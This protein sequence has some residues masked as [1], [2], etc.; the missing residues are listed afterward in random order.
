[1]LTWG[2]SDFVDEK[3]G[4]SDGKFSM[5]LQFPSEEYSTEDT[6]A[7]L[8]N[9]KA[10]E[11]KIKELYRYYYTNKNA[12]IEEVDCIGLPTAYLK[13]KVAISLSTNECWGSSI[14]IF[15]ELINADLESKNVTVNNISHETHLNEVGIKD[16]LIYSGKLDLKNS[17]K[18]PDEKDIN[19]SGDHH[20]NKVLWDFAQKLLKNV[21]VE[22]VINNIVFSPNAINFIKNIYPNGKIELILHWEDAGYGMV[23]QTTGRNYRETEA[24][25][26]I[27]KK[28]FDK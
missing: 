20:G 18:T 24:I 8:K 22:G 9:M 13:E 25:A 4:Q 27:L 3:T 21:Y 7:F 23:I 17:S 14:I 5:S 28:E 12:G 6:K 26:K 11:D 19:L 2:A 16:E 10:L 1:M 15:K